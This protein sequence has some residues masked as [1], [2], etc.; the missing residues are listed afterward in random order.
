MRSVRKGLTLLELLLV[1]ALSAV[2]VSLTYAFFNATE[3][4]G[5]EAVKT[6]EASN[7]VTP[8]FVLLLR[9]LES[10]NSKYGP[11]RVR[12]GPEGEVDSFQFY[13][14]NCY[15]FKGVCKVKYWFLNREGK[16]VLLLRS[17]QRLNDINGNWIDSPVTTKVDSLELLIPSADGYK[18]CRFAKEGLIKV[19][20][21]FKNGEELPLT[22]NLRG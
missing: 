18:E 12:R 15:Y 4:T 6:V 2:V 11:L 21:K 17:E 13:T 14:E 1:V 22:F 19:V 5:K 20:L 8:L 10:A 3:R 7:E 16:P 9:D